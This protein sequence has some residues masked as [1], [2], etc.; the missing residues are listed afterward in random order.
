L[1]RDQIQLQ[2]YK[3]A[4]EAITLVATCGV[5]NDVVPEKGACMMAPCGHYI[6]AGCFKD[7][8]HAIGNSRPQCSECSAYAHKETWQ[9]FFCMTGIAAAVN[10][11]KDIG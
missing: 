4:I 2:R 6:C 9:S 5:C 11:V 8:F 1:E 3:K 10:S 7:Y